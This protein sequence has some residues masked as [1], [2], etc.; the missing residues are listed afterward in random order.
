VK[1]KKNQRVGD[2]QRARWVQNPALEPCNAISRDKFVLVAAQALGRPVP[3][4]PFVL[5]YGDFRMRAVRRREG[6]ANE[7]SLSLLHL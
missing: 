5:E 4:T 3:V 1:E 7:Q 2:L 6:G